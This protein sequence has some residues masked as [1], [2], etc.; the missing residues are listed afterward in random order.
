MKKTLDQH[1]EAAD[2]RK[3]AKSRLAKNR[4]SRQVETAE[5]TTHDEPLRLIQELQIY[6]IELE[7]QNEELQ[8]TRNEAEAE[9]E[10]Y[11]DLYDFA[12]SR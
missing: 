5:C 10:R 7:L 1:T 6:Q 2:L 8:K 11:T 12:P 3:R 9:R 4:K